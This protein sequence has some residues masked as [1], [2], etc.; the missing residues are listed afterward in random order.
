MHAGAEQQQ[1]QQ[2]SAFAEGLIAQ[3]LDQ[4]ENRGRENEGAGQAG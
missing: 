3:Q 1:E 2:R 4:S